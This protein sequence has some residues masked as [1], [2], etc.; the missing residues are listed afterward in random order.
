MLLSKEDFVFRMIREAERSPYL[1][2][3]Y[4]VSLI[5]SLHRHGIRCTAGD[6]EIYAAFA[7][8]WRKLYN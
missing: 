3:G 8:A 1:Y 5:K 2:D 6:D 7:E 4:V